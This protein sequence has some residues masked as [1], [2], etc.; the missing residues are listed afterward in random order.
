LNLLVLGRGKTGS[1]VSDYARERHHEVHSIGAEE[2]RNGVAL[3]KENL[4]G[5]DVVIDFTT[6]SA[7]IKNIESC[8]RARVS[9][10]VGT[11]GWYD[12]IPRI[13]ELV[14]QSGIGFVYGA[15]FSFGV[16]LFFEIA[17]VAAD[18]LKHGY[19]G[20]IEEI[21][22]VHK[23]DAPSGTAVKIQQI[24]EQN[25]GKTLGIASIREGDASGT[26]TISLESEFDALTLTHEAHSRRGFAEG[27]V[28]AAEWLQGKT[29][30]HDFR[31]IFL[32]V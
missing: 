29:G 5:V 9:M 32:E 25:G 30:F 21:H 18:A 4:K 12:E 6:P 1:L 28:K 7:V 10:A 3:A 14:E 23:K 24:L 15:N 17:K 19:G 27:A 8:A 16:N 11:T 31:D 13:R 26:H 22:H 2:N 20:S